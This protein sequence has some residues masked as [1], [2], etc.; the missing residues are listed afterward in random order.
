M[1]KEYGISYL[2][3]FDEQMERFA[4]VVASLANR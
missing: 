1:R 3:V 4:P 2:V